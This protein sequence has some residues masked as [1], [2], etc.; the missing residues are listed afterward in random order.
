MDPGDFHH[1]DIGENRV[2]AF[3]AAYDA[4]LTAP[5]LRT[6]LADTRV[7][8]ILSDQ[9]SERDPSGRR[10][11]SAAQ[12]AW[13]WSELLTARD[14]GYPLVFWVSLGPWNGSPG[15]DDHWQGYS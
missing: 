5:R 9:R 8:F 3:R 6:L 4:H 10:M 15:K 2:E 12:E 14:A 11:M 1:A 13:L 7:R